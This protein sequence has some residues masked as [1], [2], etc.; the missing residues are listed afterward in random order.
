MSIRDVMVKD[1]KDSYPL[2]W[3]PPVRENVH[4]K[5]IKLD[6]LGGLGMLQGFSEWMFRGGFAFI[7][8]PAK[9]GDFN[10]P[11]H[12]RAHNIPASEVEV[13]VEKEGRSRVRGRVDECMFKFCDFEMWTE[14]STVPGSDELHIKDTLVNRADYEREYQVLYHTNFGPGTASAPLLE[15]GASFIA[16]V[17]KAAPMYDGRAVEEV[18]AWDKFKGPTKDFNEAVYCVE[19]HSDANGKTL[20]GL[21]NKAGDHGVSVRYDNTKLPA[22][23]LWKNT[24]TLKEGYV[25]GLEPGTSFCYPK[26]HERKEGRVPKLAPGASVSFDLEW[27]VLRD[28]AAVEATKKE[29]AK[30]QEGKPAELLKTLAFYNKEADPRI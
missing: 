11:L 7:G 28:A 13:I 16:P 18:D 20:V 21:V 4:P 9:D 22:F 3:T 1:G 15:E 27:R 12:G 2:G 30:L 10:L 24:D 14:V 19:T 5:H 25:T 26:A 23:S 6:E 8:H 17:K 29:I